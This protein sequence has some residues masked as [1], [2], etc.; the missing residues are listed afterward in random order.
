MPP[1]CTATSRV[2]PISVLGHNSPSSSSNQ[3]SAG[4]DIDL[5]L[6]ALM[7]FG[8]AVST[9]DHQRSTAK[10]LSNSIA[11]LGALIFSERSRMAWA[12]PT[13]SSIVARF[14]LSRAIGKY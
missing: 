12:A 13:I 10:Y 2:A 6:V 14:G 8:V 11:S 5:S 9:M 7:G 3:R 1:I 4:G